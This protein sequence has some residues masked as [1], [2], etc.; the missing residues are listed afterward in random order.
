MIEELKQI[1]DGS[2][3]ADTRARLDGLIERL[4]KEREEKAKQP[5]PTPA[6]SNAKVEQP[7]ASGSVGATTSVHTQNPAK[8]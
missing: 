8:P 5:A 2:K 4:T 1:R 6:A 7:K 3:E